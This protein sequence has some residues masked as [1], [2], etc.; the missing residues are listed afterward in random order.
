METKICTKCKQEKPISEFNKNKYKKDGL[1]SE[2][3]ECHNKLYKK[4]YYNNKDKFRDRSK[5]NRKE[6]RDFLNNIKQKGCSI[7]GETDIACLDFHHLSDKKYNISEL[8]NSENLNKIKEE[9]NK[10]IILCANC[11]RKIH[12]Y[13][14]NSLISLNN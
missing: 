6:I 2:C 12:Y 14:D 7:C 3:K 13:K 5:R 8:V 1:Q 4:Y 9:L 11:H 10:C